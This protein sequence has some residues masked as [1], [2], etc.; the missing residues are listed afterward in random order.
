MYGFCRK[1]SEFDVS[2]MSFSDVYMLS[3]GTAVILFRCILIFIAVSLEKA[4]C[5]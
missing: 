5:L 3:C 1:W 2:E 4:S